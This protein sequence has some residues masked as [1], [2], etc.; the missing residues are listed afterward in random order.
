MKSE[1]RIIEE[2]DLIN[3]LYDIQERLASHFT[4]L[5][6]QQITQKDIFQALFLVLADKESLEW[7]GD[8]WD[9]NLEYEQALTLLR[10]FDFNTLLNG[11]ETPFGLIPR[12]FLMELKVR[13]K[14]KNQIWI[15][16][17]YDADPFPSNPHAHQIENNIKLDLSNGNCYK[18]RKYIY[19]VKK[20]DLLAIR[21]EAKKV[22]KGNLPQLAV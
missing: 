1:N 13:I 6:S 12:D 18:T 21:E 14:M 10:D 11:V 20:K 19:T 7:P 22:F 5:Y 3:K 15:I 9:I 17:K 16:H 2:L 4:L 8:L